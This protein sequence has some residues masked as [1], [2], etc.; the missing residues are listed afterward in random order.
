ME[1]DAVMVSTW[2]CRCLGIDAMR[3]VG[4]T[5]WTD[6]RLGALDDGIYKVTCHHLETQKSHPWA[7]G[8][9]TLLFCS[10]F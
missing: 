8:Y 4:C 9:V 3:C 5:R 6:N 10:I 1:D 2:H 7:N